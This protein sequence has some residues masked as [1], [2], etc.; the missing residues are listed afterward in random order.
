MFSKLLPIAVPLTAA[1]RA[2][3]F[4]ENDKEITVYQVGYD[5]GSGTSFTMNHN[6]GTFFQMTN[7]SG[8]NVDPSQFYS[9]RLL[10]GSVEFD[11]D[12]S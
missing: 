12:M 9:R 2:V 8:S 6:H 7:G 1:W 11:I 3:T 10:G 4:I 5:G